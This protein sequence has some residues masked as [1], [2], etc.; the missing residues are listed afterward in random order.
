MQVLQTVNVFSFSISFSK[1][2]GNLFCEVEPGYCTSVVFLFLLFTQTQFLLQNCN[3]VMF[4]YL[5]N[6]K[7]RQQFS[8]GFALFR[9]IFR[10][11]VNHSQGSLNQLLKLYDF[12]QQTWLNCY[13][14]CSEKHIYSEGNESCLNIVNCIDFVPVLSSTY[15]SNFW[16]QPPKVTSKGVLYLCRVQCDGKTNLSV[17]DVPACPYTH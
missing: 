16:Q 6:L 7:S 4:I 17:A 11:V 13:P 1:G 12:C 5:D 9:S 14:V 3:S 8:V 2:T 10:I 15:Y